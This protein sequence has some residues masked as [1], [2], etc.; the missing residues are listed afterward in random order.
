MGAGA[1]YI[2]ERLAR[3]VMMRP[4]AVV[5]RWQLLLAVVPLFAGVLAARPAEAQVRRD[6]TARRDTVPR[7]P[8]VTRADSLALARDTLQRDSTAKLQVEW[9]SPDSVMSELMAREGYTAT[10]YQGQRVELRAKEK[11]IKLEGK[12]AVGRPDAV[13]VGDTVV[14]D[15]SLDQ[16]TAV[17]ADTQQV[18]LQDPSGAQDDI[19]ARRIVY[20]I[21]TGRGKA[22]EVTT[23]VNSGQVWVVHGRVTGFQ[24]DTSAA[25]RNAFYA[26]QGWITS[27]TETTPHYHFASKEMKVIS[28][29]VMVARPAVLYI[30]DVPVFWLP[31]V[32]QDLRSGRR[33]GIIP[34]RFGVSDIVRNSPQYRRTVEDLGYYFALSDYYDAQVAMDWRSSA[35][36]ET[37]DP[38]WIRYKGSLDYRWLNRFLSGGLDVSYLKQG[39][40]LTNQTYSWS[41]DQQFSQKSRLT[42]N[43]NY[44][45]STSLQRRNTFNPTA[46]LATIDS[47]LNYQQQ[48]GAF[49]IGLGGSRKQY[50]GRDE[51]DLDFPSL[52][53]SSK[54]ISA[55]EWLTWT[56]S[57][58]MNSQQRSKIDQAPFQYAYRPSSTGAGVDSVKVNRS[59]RVTSASFETPIKIGNFT[60]TNSFRFSDNLNDFPYTKLVVDPTDSSKK[61]VLTF[62]RDYRTTLDWNTGI[63]LPSFLQS[64]WKLT[65][66]VNFENVDPGSFIVR[67][68]LSNGAWVKQKKRVRYSLSA[69]PTFFG[70]LPGFGPVDRFRHSISPVISYGY[71]GKSAVSDDYLR[72]T[73]QTRQGYIGS[74]A[75]NLVS[76]T[77]ATNV[78]AKLRAKSDTVRED[79]KTRVKLLSL[80]FTPL[81]YDFQRAKETGNSGFV[82]ERFGY[83]ARS[84][85]IPGLD[86]GVDYSLFKGSPRTSDTAEFKPF[87]EAVRGSLSLNRQSGLVAAIARLFGYDVSAPQ[88]PPTA[89]LASRDSTG[90][91][92]ARQKIAGSVN[93]AN[94]M[95]EQFRTAGAGWQ[96]DLTYSAQRYRQVA[97]AIIVDPATQCAY[98]QQVDAL[99]YDQCVQKAS[100]S[101]GV[102]DPF[103]PTTGGGLIYQSPAT[104]NIQGSTRFSITPRWAMQ[105]ST[106]YDFTRKE[107]GMHTVSLRRELHDW[108]AIF[109]FTQS[110]NGNFAFNFFIAL[111]AQP[112][113]KFNY[114]RRSY[115]RT[116]GG[117]Q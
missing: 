20:D 31:F 28:K 117:F 14:Y 59:T 76:L 110:P 100:T 23:S 106:N 78:E 84:D 5:R 54:P 8:P 60:W 112:D 115:A 30:G 102:P 53:I 64:T 3:V 40:G 10:K 95:N 77:L 25:K 94:R 21:A 24:N 79:A 4:G 22:Y 1:G 111:R 29:D 105:W 47:R 80:N 34:P 75:Q 96:V 108:D 46:A 38:G 35:G 104:Q 50:P 69:S 92:S 82:T 93:T 26:K 61:Q 85:L 114:D 17:S 68:N 83:T 90:S 73:N 39:D 6:S 12:A 33:S 9:A 56:P 81:E 11:T 27:C 107:F 48:I 89:A 15:D 51:V 7:R 103:A 19:R 91:R 55:G 109:A 41:H 116:P 88:T 13:L 87:R 18:V 63:N 37:G 98:L 97:G 32:F 45:S 49:Q 66:S 101:S 62:A 86:F 74:F 42:M 67:S 52:N 71:T 57:F 65:P 113:L 72:A 58:Q 99:A 70:L 44:A 16:V 36:A 43:L 2:H